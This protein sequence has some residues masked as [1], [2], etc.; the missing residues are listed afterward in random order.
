VNIG[1]Q[2]TFGDKNDLPDLIQCFVK[3]TSGDT[4][5][6]FTIGT[7]G[8]DDLFLKDI[9]G[10]LQLETCDSLNCLVRVTYVYTVQNDGN[11][12]LEIVRLDRTR[13][14]MDDNVVN[15]VQDTSLQPNQKTPAEEP[16]TI[17]V[18]IE[19]RIVTAVTVEGDPPSGSPVTADD[20]YTVKTDGLDEREIPCAGKSGKGKC[21]L[22]S[23]IRQNKVSVSNKRI[24]F[25]L[26][27]Q[28]QGR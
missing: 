22:L 13:E 7:T 20:T 11:T 27:R 26:S 24:S 15:L 21:F 2:V 9:F 14:D 10:S 1:S 23:V 19:A 12:Q 28:R 5:Q 17:D 16:D 8:F 25:S 6:T 3:D 18:C 4:L